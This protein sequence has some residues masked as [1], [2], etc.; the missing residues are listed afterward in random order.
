MLYNVYLVHDGA[1]PDP[2]FAIWNDVLTT[3]PAAGAVFTL[4]SGPYE[5]TGHAIVPCEDDSTRH[6]VCLRVRALRLKAKRHADATQAW[7]R[8]DEP[9]LALAT[10]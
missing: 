1:R 8:W 6:T 3:L 2:K 5:V 4:P 7:S 9:T 10:S